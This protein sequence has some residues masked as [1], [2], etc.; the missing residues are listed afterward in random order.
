MVDYYQIHILITNNIV[1]ENVVTSFSFIPLPRTNGTRVTWL[2]RSQLMPLKQNVVWLMHLLQVGDTAG[3]IYGWVPWWLFSVFTGK[4]YFCVY[5]P[6]KKYSI[7]TFTRWAGWETDSYFLLFIENR[8]VQSHPQPV[9]R[10]W[11][12]TLAQILSP[13]GLGLLHDLWYVLKVMVSG[14]FDLHLQ[15]SV[16]YIAP[17]MNSSLLLI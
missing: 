2:W 1:F 6:W 3:S 10:K 11:N 15:G 8:V 12:C 9:W 14:L 4:A 17:S 7:D 16:L 5:D 13:I